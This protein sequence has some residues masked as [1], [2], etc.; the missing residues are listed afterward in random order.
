MQLCYYYLLSSFSILATAT[1]GAP[2]STPLVLVIS[3]M[4]KVKLN[5]SVISNTLS[6]LIFM[7]KFAYMSVGPNVTVVLPDTK[8]DSISKGQM[9]KVILDYYLLCTYH[10]QYQVMLKLLPKIVSMQDD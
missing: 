5:C 7:V 8:S 1:A 6:S 4:S 9:Y 3:G 2:S 10:Q